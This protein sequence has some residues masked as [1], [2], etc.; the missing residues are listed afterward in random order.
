MRNRTLMNLVVVLLLLVPATARGEGEPS[1]REQMEA[2]QKRMAEQ[3]AELARLRAAQQELLEKLNREAAAPA[4]GS[5]PAAVKME[6]QAVADG[7]SEP[8][9]P[10]GAS[11]WWKNDRLHIG[12]YGSFRFET[13]NISGGEFIPGGSASSFTF[14][15]FV[16]TT[17][18]R[19]SERIRIYSETELERLVE[20][21][22]E[23]R[24]TREAGGVRFAEEVEGNNGA[25]IGLEQLW[26]QYDFGRGQGLRAGLILPP[27]GRFNINHDDDYWD[28]PRRTLVDRN[29]PVVPVKVAWRELGVGWVGSWGIGATAKLDYQFYVLNGSTLDF[30]LESIAQTRTPR[31][32]KLELEAELGLASG[33]VDGTKNAE[34]VSWRVALSPTLAGEIA[35]SGYH[36]QYTPSFISVDELVNSLGVDG[37]WAWGRLEF[38]GEAIYS[39]F[40]DTRRVAESFAEAVFNSSAETSR[41]ETA[42]LESEIEVELAGLSRR[43]YGFWADLKYHWRP[44]FL[45]NTFVGRGF[46]DPQLIPIVRYERVWLR[47]EF[48]ELAFSGGVLTGLEAANRQQD[49]LSL[50]VNYRPVQQVGF[51]IVYEHNN[52]LTGDRLIFPQVKRRSSDGLL[53]GTTFSF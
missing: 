52:R 18:S 48:E 24:A 51:Q 9:G 36:G 15:R 40:G 37:K 26:I 23:K 42:E 49:R 5:A 12:G 11:P 2:L 43:R 31:R 46:E 44:A 7:Q 19:V 45:K 47:Q 1:L 27:L 39:T 16:L 29:A 13:N 6:K 4:T 30:N 28:I 3:E 33:A 32:N 38:E 8:P 34:A 21:E 22:L 20:L 10:V 14:R 25:E 41:S 50:G 35:L 17:D 53:I